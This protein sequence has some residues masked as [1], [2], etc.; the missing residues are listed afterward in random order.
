MAIKTQMRL[1]QL[2]GSY[3]TSSGQI[4]DQA[5]LSATGSLNAQSMVDVVSHL[6]SAIKKIHGADS[7]AEANAGEF[8]QTLIPA[9]ADGAALGSATNEWSDL[10][11]ADGAEIKFGNDQD[12]FLS[13]Q[14][15]RGIRINSSGSFMFRDNTIFINSSAANTLDIEAPNAINI[16]TD[17]S[18]VAITIGHSTSEVTIA[19]NLTVTGDLTVSGDTVTLNTANLSV[20]DRM[21]LVHNGN[22]NDA[23]NVNGTSLIAFLSGSATSNQSAI[24]GTV[25]NDVMGVARFDVNGGEA[26]LDGTIFNNLISFRASAIQID[27]AN[28]TISMD[29]T[30]LKVGANDNLYLSGTNG[31][32]IGVDPGSTLMF[33][34]GGTNLLQFEE[35]TGNVLAK[36]GVGAALILSGGFGTT[37]GVDNGS[38]I[39]FEQ[40][41]DP[42]G[43]LETYQGSLVLSASSYAVQL[44][45]PI[46]LFTLA[47][48]RD[49]DAT[50]GITIAVGP[51]EFNF[52]D[53]DAQNSNNPGFK[54]VLNDTFD[55][56]RLNLSGALRFMEANDGGGYVA[57]KS[58]TLGGSGN[59]YT[60][61]LPTTAGSSGQVLQTNGS[62]VLSWVSQGGASNSSK[63][64]QTIAATV[65]AATNVSADSGFNAINTTAITAAQADNA[66]DVY[67]NGQLMVSSSVAYAS[68]TDTSAGDYSISNISASTDLRFTFN[69][70]ADDVVTVVVR[71]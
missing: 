1:T 51:G 71:A 19:D 35:S 10:F 42:F 46:G 64:A 58:P 13:H 52:V 45:S 27:S 70:E 48:D 41:G 21:I 32:K 56:Q 20:E 66:L 68:L 39:T 63:T 34:V 49:S 38:N 17:N 50:N 14:H 33:E 11:L 62:G 6:A 22:I 59:A 69:L 61:T 4:N 5:T 28:D 24:F 31:V 36:A 67:V 26:N 7:F 8:N 53:I 57:L 15:D 30:N 40:G 16:G 54:F 37:L 44:D 29:S 43:T 12:I 9:T 18:G 65:N 3:G 25:A 60:L 23:D 55:N 47:G 2:T